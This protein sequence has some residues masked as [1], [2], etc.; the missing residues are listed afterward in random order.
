MSKRVVEGFCPKPPDSDQ[1]HTLCVGKDVIRLYFLPQNYKR[2]TS[3]L[4][5]EGFV[6]KM[7]H[8]VDFWVNARF[9]IVEVLN[10][11]YFCEN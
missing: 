11:F 4:E 8:F 1:T 10:V 3:I 2:N 6:L 5:V 9:C 7:F